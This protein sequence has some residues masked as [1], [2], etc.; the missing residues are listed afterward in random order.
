MN[1]LDME[2]YF[3]S[4]TFLPHSPQNTKRLFQLLKSKFRLITGLL[5]EYYLLSYYFTNLGKS[6]PD[7]YLFRLQVKETV[8]HVSLNCRILVRRRDQYLRQASLKLCEYRD[9]LRYIESI[10]LL[11]EFARCKLFTL[12]NSEIEFSYFRFARYKVNFWL[13][14]RSAANPSLSVNVPGEDDTF[15]H[16]Y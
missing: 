1:V 11:W 10:E 7:V 16:L 15:L 3:R 12:Y 13:N 8:E 2:Q 6:D 14:P 9:C 4:K 5:T